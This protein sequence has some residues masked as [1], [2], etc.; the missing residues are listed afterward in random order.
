[1]FFLDLYYRIIFF[2]VIPEIFSFQDFV[3]QDYYVTLR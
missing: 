1:M 3:I 2:C